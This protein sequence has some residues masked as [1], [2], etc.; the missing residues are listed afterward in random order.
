MSTPT[1]VFPAAVA[2]DAQL[3]VANNLVQ[4]TLKVAIG[5][6]DT[7]LFVNSAAGFTANC[8]VSIDNEI[9]AVAS[10]T[11]SPNATLNVASG[12]RGFDGTAAAA[13]SPGAKISLFIDAWHH[14]VLSAE[15]KAIEAALGSNLS[16]IGHSPFLISRD[17][18]FAPQT[19][20]GTLNAGANSI[21]LSPMPCG[22]AVGGYLYI[23][24]G[25]GAAEAVPITGASSTN[26]IVTCANA[27]SGAWTIQSATS[28]IQEALSCS[29][30]QY[31]SAVV[32]VPP[33]VSLIY[34][35][36][37][38]PSYST[39]YGGGMGVSVIR[40]APG[41]WKFCLLGGG[42]GMCGSAASSYSNIT[43]RSLE[44]D[45]NRVN[46]TG[47]FT[48]PNAVGSMVS[49]YGTN[50]DHIKVEDC[51]A[52][53]NPGNGSVGG[54]VQIGFDPAATGGEW[55]MYHNVVMGNGYGG[56]LMTTAAGTKFIGN[57]CE[58]TWGDAGLVVNGPNS[59]GS[60]V[61]G[62]RVENN[63]ISLEATANTT[64]VGNV[65]DPP[66]N[67]GILV[68]DCGEGMVVVGNVIR[69]V[70]AT[71]G[72]SNGNGISM[73][74]PT[75]AI[76]VVRTVAGNSI[77]LAGGSSYDFAVPVPATW[78]LL[79]S[80]YFGD[81]GTNTSLALVNG[82][83][84][85]IAVPINSLKGSADRYAAITGPTAA[86]SLGG[87]TGGVVGARLYMMNT[88]TQTMTVNNQDGG[89]SPANKFYIPGTPGS[90]T[91]KAFSALYDGGSWVIFTYI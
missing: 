19:P 78:T 43:V 84:Q 24:G 32:F 28:G 27:H 67:T 82:A 69:N 64:V 10:V 6:T 68:S 9:I 46:N 5:T 74:N 60:L 17:Y 13:H 91:C 34:G 87:V 1:A 30:A 26:V 36:I 49:F 21:T 61:V 15:V 58:G 35:S 3:K 12:G 77:T 83:N 56:G 2:T 72:G 88:T 8:L 23:S 29:V 4:T 16:N 62:N 63:G 81:V 48:L 85:N 54:Y 59:R 14:N 55:A 53:D 44:F 86:F 57:V 80:V 90:I 40:L 7:I 42:I 37:V 52:H 20:G 75:T 31:G 25:T 47:S 51:Y 41:C 79:D 45:G 11:T 33:G 65:V 89:S 73:R 39:L 22:M 50:G 76:P 66:F 18:N 70:P 71:G 38:M